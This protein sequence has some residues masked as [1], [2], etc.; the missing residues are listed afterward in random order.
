MFTNALRTSWQLA[1]LSAGLMCLSG[2]GGS[3]NDAPEGADAATEKTS[4]EQARE[5][6]VQ[7]EV[8]IQGKTVSQWIEALKDHDRKVNDD[9]KA[10]LRTIGPEAKSVVPVLTRP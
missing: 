7:N 4:D 2:Y 5:H 6:V 10:A 3:N 8:T 1:I 9:A